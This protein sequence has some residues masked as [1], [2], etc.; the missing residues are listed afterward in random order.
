[1][2]NSILIIFSIFFFWSCINTDNIENN[3]SDLENSNIPSDFSYETSKEVLVSITVPE[4]LENAVFKLASYK[5]DMDSTIFA[6]GGFDENSHYEALHSVASYIDTIKLISQY[7]GL[8]TDF[9]IPIINNEAKIDLTSIY[10]GTY[11]ND[12]EIASENQMVTKALAASSF[13]YMGTYNRYGVPNYLDTKDEIQ[14]NLLDDINT[15]LPEGTPL[16]ITH[17]QYL[18]D[19]ERLIHLVKTADVWVTFVTEGA[20]YRNALGYYTYPTNNPPASINDIETLNIVYP[21]A[22]LLGSGGG[23]VP[24]H[25]VY[26]GRFDAN[27]TVGW[28]IVSNGWNGSYVNYNSSSIYYSNSEFNPERTADRQDHMVSLYDEARELLILGFE[29]INRDNIGCDNDFNDAVYYATVNPFEAVSK[30]G[31]ETIEAAND[32]DGDGVNDEIDDFPYDPDKAF[33]NF[34]PAQ[35]STGSLAFEDLWP[36]TGDYDFNDLIVDY[37]FNLIAN[38]NNQIT[39]MN[40]EFIIKHIGGALN[41]GFAFVLPVEA[42]KIESVQNQIFNVGYANVAENG[43]ENDV[44]ETVIFVAEG[45]KSMK[46]DTIHLEIT[47]TEGINTSDLG[48]VPYKPILGN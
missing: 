27:T 16:T 4:F 10:D 26:L 6:K 24:G 25:K 45:V 8:V 2:K 20:G 28:F 37:N 48:G 14:Q 21:N 19:A 18:E 22:S 1:M 12:T 33:N 7:A 17:P 43:V 11:V 38:A 9:P 13:T 39:K 41:N 23:L 46:G 34:Y 3:L 31:I 30:T 35:G 36:S 32:S 47:F 40:A 44:D 29:D 42:N 15:S 5:T